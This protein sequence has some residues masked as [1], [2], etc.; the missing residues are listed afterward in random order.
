MHVAISR[1]HRISYFQNNNTL[2]SSYINNYKFYFFLLFFTF[3]LSSLASS[4]LSY[5][6]D[7]GEYEGEVGE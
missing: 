4:S 5:C 7:V 1:L 6:G 2:Y 3:F